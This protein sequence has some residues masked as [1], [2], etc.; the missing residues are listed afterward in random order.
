MTTSERLLRAK[1]DFDDVFEAGKAQGDDFWKKF[2]SMKSFAY[3]FYNW[4]TSVF[5]P[6]MELVFKGDCSRAFYN[7]NNDKAETVNMIEHLSKCGA[8]LNFSKATVL[9]FVFGTTKITALPILDFSGAKKL[10][11]CFN[12]SPL[13]KIEKII[14]KADGTQTFTNLTFNCVPLWYIRFDG[15]IGNDIWFNYCVNLD[16]ESYN[17]I[18]THCS[19]TASFTLT[20]PPEAT[21]RSVYDAKYGAGAWNTITAEYSNLTISYM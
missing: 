11:S 8:S 1:Q 3:A 18:I 9:T 14:L 15:V 17:E 5:T 6:N 16:A 21:V 12:N 19:K 13:E 10:D 7:F 2:M 4:D 20:L